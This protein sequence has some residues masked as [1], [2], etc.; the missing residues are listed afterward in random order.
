MKRYH[1]R[2][3]IL[4]F[5]VVVSACSNNPVSSPVT[6]DD[7]FKPIYSRE[8]WGEW[9]KMDQSETWQINSTSIKVNGKA[10]ESEVSLAK[11]SENVISVTIN[12]QTD[13]LY[14][15]RTASS[16]SITGNVTTGE[17]ARA[18]SA[19]YASVIVQNINDA[20]DKVETTTDENGD[21]TA[22]NLIV[23]E[24]YNVKI[25]DTSLTV[26]PSFWNFA[27]NADKI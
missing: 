10:L 20:N 3:I 16:S 5:L 15:V 8:Y 18:L 21:F 24:N 22:D 26:K 11:P 4:L 12:G 2:L 1:F 9:K 6:L 23:G 17:T 7:T 13:C 19:G 14:A 27:F 25:G